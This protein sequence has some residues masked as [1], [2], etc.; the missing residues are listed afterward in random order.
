VDPMVGSVVEG[1]VDGRDGQEVRAEAVGR[2]ERTLVLSVVVE[3][4]PSPENTVTLSPSR[5]SFGMPLNR[6]RYNPGKYAKRSLEHLVADVPRRLRPLGAGEATLVTVPR[7]SHLLG[8]LRMGVG[9]KGVVD[10]DLRHRRFENL[11]VSGGA[12]FPTY[13]ATHPTLTIA[14][15]AIRL[16]RTLARGSA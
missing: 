12:V 3:D 7:G 14:A 16:G 11:F 5:D 15:L 8:T 13:A 2:W 1:I 10:P 9:S 4:A 6:V